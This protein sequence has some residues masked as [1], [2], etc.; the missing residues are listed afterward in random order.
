M[1]YLTHGIQQS[2]FIN[3]K[4]FTDM[5]GPEAQSESQKTKSSMDDASKEA[6]LDNA[7]NL[8]NTKLAA[9]FR[10][11]Y[12][13]KIKGNRLELKYKNNGVDWLYTFDINADGV[14]IG[15]T[16]INLSEQEEEGNSV[17]IIREVTFM[18]LYAGKVIGMPEILKV[19]GQNM[20]E[21]INAPPTRAE[22]ER[23]IAVKIKEVFSKYEA[24]D[25]LEFLQKFKTTEELYSAVARDLKP[26][27]FAL[28][29]AIRDAKINY[30]PFIGECNMVCTNERL[31]A[32]YVGT[33][34]GGLFI[35]ITADG[36]HGEIAYDDLGG[37]AY[38]TLIAKQQEASD[39]EYEKYKTAL[40][41]ISS[42]LNNEGAKYLK[43]CIKEEY[44]TTPEQ[45]NTLIETLFK[46]ATK[47][48]KTFEPRGKPFEI[49][50]MQSRFKVLFA[51]DGIHIQGNNSAFLSDLIADSNINSKLGEKI[52]A[53]QGHK[54]TDSQSKIIRDGRHRLFET[55]REHTKESR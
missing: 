32:K 12:K 33:G 45:F 43:Y 5:A 8:E 40:N 35:E 13:D 48:L 29:A 10:E 9:R 25:A 49:G 26:Y 28:L 46:T 38:N 39:P 19:L 41:Y 31:N 52:I 24:M 27:L 54:L 16:K 15:I 44:V 53:S 7:K 1:K 51:A 21:K 47:N 11:D 6:D 14:K 2:F 4:R 18:R 23:Q 30:N 37:W 20:P 34:V 3:G 36:S 17:P 55:P 22:A 42:Y 50:F